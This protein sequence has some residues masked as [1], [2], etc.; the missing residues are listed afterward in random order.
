MLQYVKV[1]QFKNNEITKGPKSTEP[2]ETQLD[3]DR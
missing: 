3:K 2:V 1:K